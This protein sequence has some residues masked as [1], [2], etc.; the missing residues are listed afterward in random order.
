MDTPIIP[1]K[2]CTRCKEYFP[3]TEECFRLRKYR[4][5]LFAKCRTCEHEHDAEI[6]RNNPNRFSNAQKRFRENKP[7]RSK[8]IK[9]KWVDKNPAKIVQ[10][11]ARYYIEKRDEIV[12]RN[13][14]YNEKHP[15]KRRAR[16]E[17]RRRLSKQADGSFT[18]EDLKHIYEE[19]EC[20]CAYC[21]ISIYWNVPHDLHVDHIEPLSKGGSNWPS[22]LALTCADCNLTK[23]QKSIK[24]WMEVRGW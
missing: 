2:R 24:E 14:E 15:E 19:Q 5:Q 16:T 22:N 6:R 18:H 7:E 10:K 13:N 21:G 8:E 9:Q 20:R 3:A 4:N 11:N 23:G 17:K 12:K 1:Q